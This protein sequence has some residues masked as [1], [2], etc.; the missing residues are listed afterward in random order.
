MEGV[1]LLIL[2]AGWTATFLIPLLQQHPDS[3]TFAA[4]TTTGRPVCGIDTIPFRFDPDS[5]DPTPIANLPRARYILITFPLTGKGQST[6]LTE[7]YAAT[8]PIPSPSQEKYRFIQ[9]GSTGIWQVEGRRKRHGA[10]K[11]PEEKQAER[12][13]RVKAEAE[14]AAEKK[15]NNNNKKPFGF[16]T[17]HS[18]YLTT[19]P[20]AI[21]ED[22]LLASSV[23]DGMVLA[24]SGLWGGTRDP[25]NWVSRVAFSKEAMRHKTSLHMIHGLDIAR[26]V[27]KIITTC[28]EE[29]KEEEGG[30]KKKKWEEHGKGQRWMLTDGFVYDWW[31]L[32]MGWATEGQ[33]DGEP[34]E[35]AK[36]VMELMEEEGVQALPRSMELMGRAYDS[37]E[38]WRTWGLVPVKARV[39]VNAP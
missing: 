26:A 33:E 23:V 30:E 25:R 34:R 39:G 1:D 22:E 32:L 12:E 35:Q 37:R 14:A 18:P 38:F 29:K 10:A 15:K 5:Q 3:L 21:A 20:R 24:L 17:R 9:F 13:A 36:W 11:T 2:G 31:S 19:D 28:E 27:F 6:W 7:T 16:T 8:H 4:T